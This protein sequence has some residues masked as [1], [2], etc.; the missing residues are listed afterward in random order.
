MLI[1][2][3]ILFIIHMVCV[4]ENFDVF[5]GLHDPVAV[6]VSY[7]VCDSEVAIGVHVTIATVRHAVWPTVFMMELT[8]G[9]DI[10]T[11]SIRIWKAFI[12]F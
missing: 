9:T 6:T 7:V 10:V 1:N 5:F 12:R 3:F 2:W 11:K 4:W 8:I